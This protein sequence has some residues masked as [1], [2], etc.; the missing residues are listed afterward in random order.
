MN[1]KKPLISFIIITYKQED[2]VRQAIEGALA[3]TYSPLEIIISDDNSSDRTFSIIEET[4]KN[5]SGC[6]T[7][8]INRTQKNLGIGAHINTVMNMCSGEIIIGSAGDDISLPER[9]LKCYEEFAKDN[10][11]VMSVWSNAVVIN[12]NNKELSY[13]NKSENLLSTLPAPLHDYHAL[14]NEPQ[15]ECDYL[16]ENIVQGDYILHGCT[17]AWRREIFDFFGPMTIPVTYED[18][19]L[20]LRSALIGSIRYIDEVLV[21][22]RQHSSNITNFAL[23][24]NTEYQLLAE[25]ISVYKNWLK[26][27]ELFM[28]AYP[29][30]QQRGLCLK[31]T[32]EYRMTSANNDIALYTAP[33]LIRLFIII[34]RVLNG[35]SIKK[36]RKMIGI[37]LVPKIYNIYMNL[38]YNRF[39]NNL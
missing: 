34:K 15:R 23:S 21:R 13:I 22:Y 20:P 12:E 16:P 24:S 37:L 9:T 2:Y 35:T 26:D 29:K 7:V 31:N 6:H 14:Y 4:V 1:K 10:C 30:E 27:V 28:S 3:Q 39:K 17:H 36:A 8:K 33:W 25:Y 18:K 38:K 5:Y 11:S 32:I 19:V